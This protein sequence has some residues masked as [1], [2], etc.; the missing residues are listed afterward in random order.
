MNDNPA[1]LVVSHHHQDD[2]FNSDDEDEEEEE[3]SRIDWTGGFSDS[4]TPQPTTTSLQRTP[5]HNS[6]SSSDGEEGKHEEN[7]N[8][9][10]DEDDPFGDFNSNNDNEPTNQ[11]WE[12]GFS[13]NFGDMDI[14]T[15]EEDQK[16]KKDT[17]VEV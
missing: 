14:N 8:E 11:K 9:I 10:E 3:A 13:S 6:L 16:L 5:S 4:F 2:L 17:P 7:E 12:E 1:G 15:I